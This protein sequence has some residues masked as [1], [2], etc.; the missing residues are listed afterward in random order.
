MGRRRVPLVQSRNGLDEEDL[1]KKMSG[2]VYIKKRKYSLGKKEVEG[3]E[4]RSDR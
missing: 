1:K 2:N 4:D 3:E